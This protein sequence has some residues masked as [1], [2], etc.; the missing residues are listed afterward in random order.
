MNI[1]ISNQMAGRLIN[2]HDMGINLL[3]WV[4]ATMVNSEYNPYSR[5]DAM[6]PTME[7]NGVFGRRVTIQLNKI[8]K[9]QMIGSI[10]SSLD[11]ELSKMEWIDTQD[12]Q[13]Q[14]SNLIIETLTRDLDFRIISSSSGIMR[15]GSIYPREDGTILIYGLNG[16]MHYDRTRNGLIK[17]KRRYNIMIEINIVGFRYHRETEAIMSSSCREG[18]LIELP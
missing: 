15:Y 17:H 1:L 12:D 13:S 11:T 3:S 6:I 5:V 8:K 14:L 4:C 10:R 7:S 9:R 16:A 2:L 18:F